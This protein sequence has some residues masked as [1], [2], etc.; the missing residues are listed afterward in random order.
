MGQVLPGLDS[1]EEDWKCK[2]GRARI[3]GS[4]KVAKRKTSPGKG[5]IRFLYN[6]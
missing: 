1:L 5:L 3:S 4:R 6:K 2:L